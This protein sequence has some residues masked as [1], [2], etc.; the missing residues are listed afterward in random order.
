MLL[1]VGKA[2]G[3]LCLHR[4]TRNHDA[5]IKDPRPCLAVFPFALSQSKVKF[6]SESVTTIFPCACGTCRLSTRR[7]P[8]S[9]IIIIDCPVCHFEH[10]TLPL[11]SIIQMPP[12]S[13]FHSTH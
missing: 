11:S 10:R 13:N 7:S 4:E 5:M 2:V 1:C 12:V 9:Y 3:V 6:Q 8:C